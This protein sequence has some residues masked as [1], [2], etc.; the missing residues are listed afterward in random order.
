MS[1]RGNCIPFFPSPTHGAINQSHAESVFGRSLF[2]IGPTWVSPTPKT[3]SPE[4]GEGWQVVGPGAGG[5]AQ[6]EA[7]GMG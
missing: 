3:R 6:E 5:L 1:G 4:A 2:P 7:G